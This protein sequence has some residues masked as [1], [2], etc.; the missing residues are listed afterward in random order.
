[1][2]SRIVLFGATGFTGRLVAEALLRRGAAPLLVGRSRDRLLALREDLAATYPAASDVEVEV[3]DATD[4]TAVARLLR[5]QDVLVTTVGPFL[6]VGL[7]AV[8]AAAEVGATY[9]D[10]TGEPPFVR[11]VVQDHGP[12]A[13][14][15]GA[16][17]V[18]AFGYDYVPGNLAGALALA[19][20][21]AAATAVRVGYFVTGASGPSALSGGTVAS[22][23][24]M[25]LEEGYAWRAGTLLP[26]RA[27]AHVRSFTAAGRTR[28]AVS[29]A[30]SEHLFLPREHPTLRDVEVYLGWTG[31]L[32]RAAQV[33]SAASAVLLQAPGA[34]PVVRAALRRLAPGSSGGPDAGARARVR[35]VAVA[36]ALDAAGE[37]LATVELHGPS[38]YDLTAELLA[39]AATTA[40][41][42][43]VR[44]VGALG[45]VEA[46]GLAPLTGACAAMG[47]VRV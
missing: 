46:F 44:G 29:L 43:G 24:G 5:R 39:W 15:T 14:R 18:P 32:S 38:P 16:A 33:S 4:T 1:M 28:S 42:D 6:R 9:L 17:L 41:V 7:P 31:P 22:A 35:T 37:V 11:R 27:A 40:A 21:G 30:G 34:R 25:V 12:V 26:E 13:E 2:T 19:E 23:A 8:T 36:E 45:P 47:L 10:S 3:A 20:A